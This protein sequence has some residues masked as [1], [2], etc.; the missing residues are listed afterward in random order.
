MASFGTCG[1]GVFVCEAMIHVN[2]EEPKGL[3]DFL[4]RWYHP[5]LSIAQEF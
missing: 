3:A 1:G 4:Y 5:F 2:W